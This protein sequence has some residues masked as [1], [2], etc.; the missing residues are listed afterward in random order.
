MLEIRIKKFREIVKLEEDLKE[1]EKAKKESWAKYRALDDKYEAKFEKLLKA[2]KEADAK[3][4]Q[5][6]VAV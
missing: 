4:S 3:K 1:A 2:Q 6:E 5:E